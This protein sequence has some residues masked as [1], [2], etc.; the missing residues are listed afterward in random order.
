[1]ASKSIHGLYKRGKMWYS[2]I[3]DGSGRI[4][5]KKLSADKAV[6]EQILAEMRR[7]FDLQKAGLL[8][9]AMPVRVKSL[10]DLRDHYIE[11]LNSGKAAQNSIV[12]FISAWKQVVEVNRLKNVGDLTLPGVESWA[13][14]RLDSGIRGQTV[15]LY[16]LLVQSALKWGLSNG[17]LHYNPLANWRPVRVNEPRKRRDLFPH[18]ARAILETERNEEWRLRWLVYLYTGLRN[19][20]GE[21]VRWEWMEW[22]KRELRLPVEANKSKKPLRIPLHPELFK[23]L[24]EWRQKNLPGSEGRIFPNKASA[25]TVNRRFKGT[26]RKAGLN[27]IDA[28]TTHSTRHTFATMIYE[29]T[30]KNIKAVQELLGHASAATTLRYLHLTD[31]ER[32]AAITALN[33]GQ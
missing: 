1:M 32:I 27:D 15:N 28:L 9:D 8:P 11:H 2:R 29:G 7:T 18:E 26:C 13:K 17:L 22:E 23:A 24:E 4:V 5:R 3:T 31:N 6:A 14:R 33:Y 12:A 30:G 20:A 16:V 21:T 10:S 19:E 25:W